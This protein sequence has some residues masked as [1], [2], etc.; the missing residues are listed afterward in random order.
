M[1]RSLTIFVN[2]DLTSIL[3]DHPSL[4][5]LVISASVLGICPR[6]GGVATC[7]VLTMSASSLIVTLVPEPTLYTSLSF[8]C[9][10][11][12]LRASIASLTCTKS[13]E[14]LMSLG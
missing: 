9:S 11:I 4:V 5:S 14:L 7:L 12:N 13:L 2:H 8:P 3:G 1:L 10:I 6:R